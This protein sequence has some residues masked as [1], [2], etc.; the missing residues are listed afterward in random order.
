MTA[1]KT[2]GKHTAHSEFMTTQDHSAMA[3]ID[4]HRNASKHSRRSSGTQSAPP[5][6]APTGS[7]TGAKAPEAAEAAGP[8]SA[9]GSRTA[10]TAA[11]SA[12]GEAPAARTGAASAT[13]IG[14]P[15]VEDGATIWRIARNSKA[16]DLNSS[17]SYLLWCRDFARTSVVA[18]SADG[19]P[20]GFV[21]GYIRPERPRTLVV[22]QVAVDGAHR[23]CG[24]AGAMLDGLTR[25]VAAQGV[26][27][28]ETTITPDNAASIRL[29][30]SYGRRHRAMVTTE[31]LFDGG[32][33]PDSHASE[34]LYRI[35][36]LRAAAA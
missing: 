4:P 10:A 11:A 21:T 3:V 29:F 32:L 8:G 7:G 12:P 22:W 16:L 35:G 30:T 27:E 2:A 31:V 18:R 26:E 19:T 24:L 15:E 17:Y 6:T 23:G 20:V 14:H 25:Q 34:V 9:A 13:V 36:P 1:S 33:F 5:L 28:L